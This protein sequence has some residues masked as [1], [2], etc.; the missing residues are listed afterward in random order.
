MDTA[1]LKTLLEVAKPRHLGRAAD[2]LFLTQSAISAR[3]KLLEEKLG[4]ALFSRK[5][6]DIQL[7]PAGSR[8][9]RHAEGIVKSW[10]RA[11]QSVA[12]DPEQSDSLA[13]GCLFDLWRICVDDWSE[14]LQAANPGLVL[15]VEILTGEVLIHRLGQGVIDIAFLFDPPQLPDLTLQ[16]IRDVPLQLYASQPQ[17]PLERALTQD[18]L[19]VDWGSAFQRA[20]ADFFPEL[21][22][23]GLRTNSGQVALDLLLRRGGAAYLPEA[24]ASPALEQARLFPVADAPVINRL[25]YA[26]YHPEATR[27]PALAAALAALS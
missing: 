27:R 5:R 21:P 15:Q 1:L 7:T 16:Q 14:R 2:H 18:Y 6:N 19:L 11:R 3:I 17:L 13:A 12:L 23:P 9:C 10:E 22:S 25:A 24:L 26:A 20:H 8:L 4:V